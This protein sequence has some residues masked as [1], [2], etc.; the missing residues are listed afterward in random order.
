ME[1]MRLVRVLRA[2]LSSAFFSASGSTPTLV[3][4]PRL[5]VRFPFRSAIPKAQQVV[6][7]YD[8]ISV[9]S[10]RTIGGFNFSTGAVVGVGIFNVTRAIQ[11]LYA[12]LHAGVRGRRSAHT[13][14]GDFSGLPGDMLRLLSPVAYATAV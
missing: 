8:P 7:K 13:W 6:V 2:L 14:I 10:G 9:R 5:F 11:G 3:G 1:C 12:G 4:S